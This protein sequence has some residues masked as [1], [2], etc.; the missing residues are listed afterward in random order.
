MYPESQSI[1][2]RTMQISICFSLI[3]ALILVF[4]NNKGNIRRDG[5]FVPTILASLWVTLLYKD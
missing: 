4:F 5:Y 3:L 1:L 2:F